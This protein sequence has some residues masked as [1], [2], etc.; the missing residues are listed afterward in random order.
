MSTPARAA[1]Y[2]RV[3][4]GAQ[5]AEGTSLASQEAACRRYA[6]EHGY[7]VAEAH[8][9]REV[10]TGAE[11]WERPHLA[12]LREVV[13]RKEIGAVIIYALDR[14][15]RKQAHVAIIADEGERAGVALLFVTEEFE[16]SAVG[17][18]IRA[19]KS[20]AAE[21]EREK[22]M[23]RT[24]RGVQG[25]LLR[26]KLPPM[27]RPPY[28]YRW[29]GEDKGA[30]DVDEATA[31]TLRRVF[32]DAASGVSMHKIAERLNAAGVPT[33][34]GVG[35]WHHPTLRTIL[36]KEAYTGVARA[37]QTDSSKKGGRR[38]RVP[39]P[40]EEQIVLPEGTVPPLV[41][42]E[43][44]AAV[45][46]RLARNKA[47]AI[48][49]HRNPEAFLLR[50]GVIRCAYCGRALTTRPAYTDSTGK[51]HH[52]RYVSTTSHNATCRPVWCDAVAVDADIWGRV[53]A[54]LGDPAIIVRELARRRQSDPTAADRAAVERALADVD[55]QQ[56]NLARTL[57]LIE[58]EDST[59][60]LLGELATLGTRKRA[61]LAERET[62]A[63]RH[64]A[65]RRD[66]LS[67]DGIEAWCR[68]VGQGLEHAD[69]AR[70]RKALTALGVRVPLY[71]ADHTPRWDF[72]TTFRVA[73]DMLVP[74]EAGMIVDSRSRAAR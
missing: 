51:L 7:T 28:G 2:C 24:R 35:R 67:L 64:E 50:A 11:L 6:S 57:A 73:G 56:A 68:K 52:T 34:T 44:F 72:E 18:F 62:L 63:A 70:K 54:I 33:P 42:R 23:E 58:D 55:R 22:L 32:A 37:N 27:S 36:T 71:A 61:L 14:L 30:L 41:S 25:R 19:A 16:Q 21:V 49:N 8:V 53:K 4:T 20:F 12:A 59:T 43:T 47:E 45:Q 29:R 74:A 69:Y 60:P 66:Q 31:P 39:R 26:G 9:Y 10:H 1:I 48:R 17:E 3:S 40:I 15:S 46:S 13:R 38:Q 5:E 65:W